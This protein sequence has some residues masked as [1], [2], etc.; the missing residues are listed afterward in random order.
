M[1][2]QIED[3]LHRFKRLHKMEERDPLTEKI[4]GCCY[5]VHKELGPAFNEKIYQK[6]QNERPDPHIFQKKTRPNQ[7]S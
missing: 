1:I 4:I 5:K 6:C 2:T 7:R 3:R